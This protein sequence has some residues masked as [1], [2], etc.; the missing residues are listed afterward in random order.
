MCGLHYYK[1]YFY[2][3]SY[4]TVQLM[5]WML[6]F[7]SSFW[8]F[9]P[10][11]VYIILIFREVTRWIFYGFKILYIQRNNDCNISTYEKVCTSHWFWDGQYL[12]WNIV[13]DV[14]V[15]IQSEIGLFV[16][17][18]TKMFWVE[19]LLEM[20]CWK[21][22]PYCWD[23]CKKWLHKPMVAVV[24]GMEGRKGECCEDGVTSR[25]WGSGRDT[26]W[27]ISSFCLIQMIILGS[28]QI[29]FWLVYLL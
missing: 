10:F 29:L 4:D 27:H 8:S 20:S 1:T 14:L 17:N 3:C 21:P 18:M 22:L 9:I 2:T 6:W 23:Q 13:L 7:G 25:S 28:L 16:L 12:D 19:G 24:D 15:H 11:I 5:G 26:E